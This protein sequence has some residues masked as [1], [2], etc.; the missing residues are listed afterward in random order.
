MGIWSNSQ[1]LLGSSGCESGR[2]QCLKFDLVLLGSNAVGMVRCTAFL[3]LLAIAVLLN[4]FSSVIIDAM[5]EHSLL[6]L[7]CICPSLDDHSLF[8]VLFPAVKV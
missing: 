3:V 6:F 7:I 4:N 8:F 1:Q 5:I 2:D